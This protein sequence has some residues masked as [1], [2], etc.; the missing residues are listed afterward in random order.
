MKKLIEI[1]S[2]IF[3]FVITFVLL[4][5]FCDMIIEKVL[6]PQDWLFYEFGPISSLL[7]VPLLAVPVVLLSSHCVYFIKKKITSEA[8]DLFGF[9]GFWKALG[10]WKAAFVLVYIVAVYFSFTNFTCVTNEKIVV[11][12]PWDLN[13]REYVYSDV[14]KI[15][16]GFGNKRFS[17]LEHENEGDFY[18]KITLDGKESV[19]HTPTVNPDIERYD[20]TYLELEEFDSALRKFGI[21]KKSSIEGYEKCDFDKI[22]VDRFLR[23]INRG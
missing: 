7:I 13:G 21:P 19:F 12:R 9:V 16:T 11:V 22:Y 23:I 2:F 15:E 1:I 20:D 14:E 10:K 5:M 17:L 4:I 6:L 3:L 8:A 18:Y